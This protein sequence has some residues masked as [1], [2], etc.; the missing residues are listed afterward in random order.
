MVYDCKECK[1]YKYCCLGFGGVEC[2]HY[3]EVN[4]EL[5]HE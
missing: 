3:E 4:K 1:H 5:K 2:S